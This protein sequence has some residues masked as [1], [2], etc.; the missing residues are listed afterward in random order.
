MSD[1]IDDGV[2]MSFKFTDRRVMI[3]VQIYREE[4]VLKR[5]RELYYNSKTRLFLK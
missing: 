5:E 4:T 3:K 1:E 2:M